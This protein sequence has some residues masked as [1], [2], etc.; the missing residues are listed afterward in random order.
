LFKIL[1]V[2]NYSYSYGFSVSPRF[3]SGFWSPL[4][5]ASILQ[6]NDVKNC[7]KV[8]FLLASV[9]VCYVV[10]LPLAT[11]YQHFIHRSPT[12]IEKNNIRMHYEDDC[13]ENQ[14]GNDE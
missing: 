6:N 5:F 8:L 14:I 9:R 12:N 1:N 11:T 3:S 4:C 10:F 13:W 2:N 7:H